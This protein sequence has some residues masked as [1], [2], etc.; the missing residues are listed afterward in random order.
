M[1]KHEFTDQLDDYYLNC[2]LDEYRD[3]L[4]QYIPDVDDQN[5]MIDRL[6]DIEESFQEILEKAEQFASALED[7]KM[8]LEDVE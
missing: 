1:I 6:K 7:I 2:Q 3:L 4:V 8:S 5:R